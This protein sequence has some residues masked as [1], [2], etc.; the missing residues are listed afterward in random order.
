MNDT[1][2]TICH[3]DGA[4][5]GRNELKKKKGRKGD[6]RSLKIDIAAVHRRKK[7]RER[8][9]VKRKLLWRRIS[10]LFDSFWR[11][12]EMLVYSAEELYGSYIFSLFWQYIFF[13]S[14]TTRALCIE[15]RWWPMWRNHLDMAGC[16]GRS[17]VY[18]EWEN[19]TKNIWYKMIDFNKTSLP[20]FLTGGPL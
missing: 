20:L 17:V 14:A 16:A 8:R 12:K 11:N 13:D 2:D 9:N 15:S 19:R 7:E 1:R 10:D 4:H 3:S 18:K 6:N 5:I